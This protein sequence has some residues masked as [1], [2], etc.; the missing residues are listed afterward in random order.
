MSDRSAKLL[1]KVGEIIEAHESLTRKMSIHRVEVPLDT[2]LM[3][4]IVQWKKGYEDMLS[5]RPRKSKKGPIGPAAIET[6]YTK[7]AQSEGAK[8]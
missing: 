1:L 4:D 2:S 8:A 7:D 6:L 5:R 3:S